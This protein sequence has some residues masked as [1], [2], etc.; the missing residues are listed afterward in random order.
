MDAY[1]CTSDQMQSVH[2]KGAQR[3]SFY[4]LSSDN[5]SLIIINL[6]YQN[7]HHA[8]SSFFQS[9]G[10]QGHPGGLF[11]HELWGLSMFRIPFSLL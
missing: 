2:L 8:F 4:F 6:C 7:V 3:K 11:D 1:T 10:S 5:L 9:T